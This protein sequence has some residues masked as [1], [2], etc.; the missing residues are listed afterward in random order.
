MTKVITAKDLENAKNKNMPVI[1]LLA[2]FGLVVK[3]SRYKGSADMDMLRNMIKE[4]ED[5]EHIDKKSRY[6]HFNIIKKYC[7]S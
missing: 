3:D 5:N 1:T 6:S 4:L 7:D 2:A